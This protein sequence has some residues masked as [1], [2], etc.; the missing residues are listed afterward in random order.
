MSKRWI[1]EISAEVENWYTTLRSKDK[2]MADRA[3]DRLAEFGPALRM[4]HARPLG[5]GLFELR[6]TCEGTARRV[7]YFIDTRAKVITLTTFRKQRQNERQEVARA[8]QALRA[9]REAGGND[10]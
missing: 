9:S 6:F 2:A 7:T 1:V 5:G 3:F 4:P 10:G 8:K